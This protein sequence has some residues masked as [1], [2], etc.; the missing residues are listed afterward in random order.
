MRLSTGR[1]QRRERRQQQA[2]NMGRDRDG[3]NVQDRSKSKAARIREEAKYGK[4]LFRDQSQ[5]SSSS[6]EFVMKES[7]PKRIIE[8]KR[9]DEKRTK[10]FSAVLEPFHHEARNR[11][12]IVVS[13]LARRRKRLL[14]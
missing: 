7:G 11:P 4:R 6:V 1:R 9:L 5:D 8:D 14:D 12:R 2:K 13:T 10:R 3:L